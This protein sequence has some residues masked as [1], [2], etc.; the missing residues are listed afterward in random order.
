MGSTAAT[1]HQVCLRAALHHP[2]SMNT[3]GRPNMYTVFRTHHGYTDGAQIT[4]LRK[5]AVPAVDPTRMMMKCFMRRWY[6]TGNIIRYWESYSIR[7]KLSNLLQGAPSWY[8]PSTS[9]SHSSPTGIPSLLQTLPG[10]RL[11]LLDTALQPITAN[12]A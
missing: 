12:D 3:L 1:P 10:Q 11:H 9:D 4:L 8:R 5:S 6:H 7:V 2:R